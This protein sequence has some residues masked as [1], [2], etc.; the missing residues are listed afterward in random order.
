[1]QMLTR[2]KA[3]KCEFRIAS[4]IEGHIVM[5]F[6]LVTSFTTIS[7]MLVGKSNCT[8][9]LAPFPRPHDWPLEIASLPSETAHKLSCAKEETS[10][11]RIVVHSRF[12]HSRDKVKENGVRGFEATE[13]ENAPCRTELKHNY[14]IQWPNYWEV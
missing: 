14:L 9:Q 1:M 10:Q 13:F 3:R 7:I 5:K 8:L 11:M 12:S 2:S 6:F 4:I